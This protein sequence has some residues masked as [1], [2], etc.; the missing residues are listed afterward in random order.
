MLVCLRYVIR[1][2]FGLID[3]T[4]SIEYWKAPEGLKPEIIPQ[5]IRKN[6]KAIKFLI[7]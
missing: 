2:T 3:G 4:G 6:K 5:K 7:S 1:K